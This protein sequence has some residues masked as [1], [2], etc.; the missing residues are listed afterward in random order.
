MRLL[1][2][3]EIA[4]ILPPGYTACHRYMCLNGAA[5]PFIDFLGETLSNLGISPFQIH[6]NRYDILTSPHVLLMQTFNHAPS[7]DE[8]RYYLS[9]KRRHECPSLDVIEAQRNRKFMVQLQ[10]NLSQFRTWYLFVKCPEGFNNLWTTGGKFFSILI[11][12]RYVAMEFLTSQILST[13]ILMPNKGL[14]L[15]QTFHTLKPVDAGERSVKFL[16]TDEHLLWYG[17]LHPRRSAAAVVVS[18]PSRS[19]I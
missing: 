2:K 8:L 10:S 3:N 18:S 12:F 9:F 6:P 16:L 11:G 14:S 17:L 19:M 1:E 15:D 13:V 4:H 5:T 7:F